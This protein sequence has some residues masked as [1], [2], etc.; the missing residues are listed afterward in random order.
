[1]SQKP[2][3]P[4][5]LCLAYSAPHMTMMWLVTPIGVLQGIY[6]KY[7]GIS[8][9]SIAAAVL[10]VRL[11]DA[12]SDVLV[13]HYSDRYYGC[14]GTRKPFMLV[15]GLL[16]IVS[17][18]FLYVPPTQVG[19]IYFTCWYL[20]FYLAWTLFQVPHIAWGTDLAPNSEDKTLLYSVRSFADYLGLLLFYTIPL[21]PFF[22]TTEITPDTLKYS[23]IIAVILMLFFLFYGLKITTD[24]FII[25]TNKKYKL[26]EN[27]STLSKRSVLSKKRKE[28]LTALHSII[29]NKPLLLFL[30]AYLFKTLGTSMW[31][32][33]IFIFVDVYLS[34]GKEFSRMFLVATVVGILATPIWYKLAI[35]IGKKITWLISMVLI[36]FTFVYTGMLTPSD[37]SLSELLV[38]KIT[39]TLGL[40]CM[41]VVA[42]GILSEIID[43][44][45]WKDNTERGATL[46]ASYTFIIKTSG[47]I[48]SAFG[49]GIVGLYGF[50]V[51]ATSHS[52]ASTRG[53]LLAISWVP[54]A[55]ASLSLTFMM[56]ISIN[57]RNHAIIR[58]RLDSRAARA[59]CLTEAST[60][61]GV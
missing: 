30:G 1:M 38:L 27:K 53:L 7:Y 8:L 34:L 45:T 46:F 37:A 16:F 19:I 50:D 55:F 25:H 33:L 57:T 52:E 3:L 40:S 22:E 36:L 5:P 54:L 13:G 61:S 10:I 12:F 14:R 48:A 21:L 47:A 39:Q 18:Y 51:A 31:F 4:L 2:S 60:A 42:P 41:G 59:E 32:G 26:L 24:N 56:L 9:T 28:F 49:L 6:A 35:K 58:R 44:A 43:Y 11:F 23:V 17:S 15:G 20:A 29:K